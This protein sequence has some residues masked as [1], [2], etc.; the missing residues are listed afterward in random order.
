M[1]LA[2]RAANAASQLFPGRK[3]VAVT[4]LEVKRWAIVA[5]RTRLRVT[6]ERIDLGVALVNI[7]IWRDA[8]AGLSRF[9]PIVSARVDMAESYRPPP[10]PLTPLVNVMPVSIPYRLDDVFHGRSYQLV[11]AS[12]LGDHG[13]DDICS[14][15]SDVASGLLNHALLDTVYHGLGPSALARIA[16]A[17]RLDAVFLPTAI[18]TLTLHSKTPVTGEVT[19]RV[20]CMEVS[21]DGELIVLRAQLAGVAGLWADVSYTMRAFSMPNARALPT[22]A[23]IRFMRDRQ[24]FPGF[25]FSRAVGSETRLRVHECKAV[26]WFPGTVARIYALP[27][28]LSLESTT[29][30][31]AAKD[32]VARREGLHPAL[33]DVDPTTLIARCEPLS[34][35]RRFGLVS[36]WQGNEVVISDRPLPARMLENLATGRTSNRRDTV[37]K[38]SG[39]A[40]TGFPHDVVT[41]YEWMDA[42]ASNLPADRPALDEWLE[43]AFEAAR[44]CKAASGPLWW[45]ELKNAQRHPLL[46][47]LHEDPYQR[48]AFQKPRGYAGDAVML[49]MIYEGLSALSDT[50]RASVSSFGQTFFEAYQARA[51]CE[52]IRERRRELGRRLQSARRF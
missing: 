21:A 23:L 40:L 1:D 5:G 7:A 16:P 51:S 28:R 39:G 13:R 47:R 29:L 43:Q 46:K 41:N 17:S 35:A 50:E 2:E 32:H 15:D 12:Q 14:A 48:R 22:G 44:R 31:V 37:A 18:S 27:A 42:I 10:E 33:V 49:D 34:L 9:E 11:K 52:A 6:A 8:R 26:D 20:R 45:A 3:V 38:L 19:C 36:R 4:G 30:L 25:G 24:P